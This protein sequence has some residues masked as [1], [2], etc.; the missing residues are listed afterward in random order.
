MTYGDG[1]TQYRCTMMMDICEYGRVAA[2]FA[3]L[4]EA[5]EFLHIHPAQIVQTEKVVWSN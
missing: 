5:Q 3:T 2:V 4:K 1:H